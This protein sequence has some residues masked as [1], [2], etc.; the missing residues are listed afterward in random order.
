MEMDVNFEYIE[1]KI[2]VI[3]KITVKALRKGLDKIYNGVTWFPDEKTRISC[4]EKDFSIEKLP[5][6]D[7]LNEFYVRFNVSAE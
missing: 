4:L 2:I 1:E 3:S 6:R 7:T 5:K